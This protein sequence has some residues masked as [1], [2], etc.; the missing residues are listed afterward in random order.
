MKEIFMNIKINEMKKNMFCLFKNIEQRT[1]MKKRHGTDDKRGK[2]ANEM[3]YF[4]K[5]L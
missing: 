3:N 4:I 1:L 5:S 2:R